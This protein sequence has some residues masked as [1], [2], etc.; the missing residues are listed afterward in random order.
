MA[1]QPDYNFDGLMARGLQQSISAAGD[2]NIIFYSGTMP[3]D[4]DT[5]TEAGYVGSQLGSMSDF[6][7]Q[8]TYVE[9]AIGSAVAWLIMVNFNQIP[10]VFN[11]TATGTAAWYACVST[12]DTSQF[13]LGEVSDEL[14][15]GTLKVDDVAFV[16]G[17]PVTPISLAVEFNG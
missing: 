10:A 11:A 16:S 9:A 4:V 15:D 8:R 2:F 6:T 14:G 17:N 1:L 3:A 12:S 13:Y 7:Y 5:W